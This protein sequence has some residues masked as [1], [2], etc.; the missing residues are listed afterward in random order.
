MASCGKYR[1]YTIIFKLEVVRHTFNHSNAEA[2]RR[3]GVQ[4]KLVQ[5]WCH[6]ESELS[7]RRHQPGGG[8]KARNA[9]RDEE[10]YQR[11]SGN[12][13]SGK[14]LRREALRVHAEKVSNRSKTAVVGY[15]AGDGTIINFT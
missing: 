6:Q 15:N 8:L 3:Y 1:S 4:R 14:H 9:D 2:S 12:W 7:S 10:S 5:T 13:L 11:Q